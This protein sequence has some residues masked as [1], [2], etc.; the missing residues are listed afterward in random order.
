MKQTFAITGA[1]GFVA[2]RH[3]DAIRDIGGTL[4]AALDPHDA[5]GILDRYDRDVEFF[6]DPWDFEMRMRKD[7]PRYLSICSP[8]HV[9]EEHVVMGLYA[10]SNVIC[11]K[12]LALTPWDLEEIE[13]V[14]RFS[15]GK[16]STILQLRLMPSLQ[17]LRAKIGNESAYHN[18]ELRYVTPR[19]RWYQKSW[20]GA[21]A[22]SG[23][24]ITN[25]GIHL[26][27]LMVWMFGKP[28]LEPRVYTR[29]PTSASGKLI[30]Q[31]AAVNW[32]LSTEGDTP[33]RYISVD[34]QP[35]D[36]TNGFDGLHT[37]AY[38]HV[39]ETG[40]FSASDAR[41]AVELAYKLR[42][43]AITAL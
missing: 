25:I 3:L 30:L 38:R 11:E 8:N 6:T 24:I 5:V 20:K 18:V 13:N 40:G 7:P 19:G 10:G 2:P 35:L 32:S 26:L 12:P 21:E 9:H 41:P 36:F 1:G 23:G 22:L 4:V 34:D 43:M 14:E 29:T 16:L 39:L 27:D 17:A 33:W 37:A 15:G 42:T 31:S 28:T